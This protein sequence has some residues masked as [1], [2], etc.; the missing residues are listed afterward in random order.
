MTP[1]SARRALL[2]SAGRQASGFRLAQIAG[3][4]SE[5]E[6]AYAGLH[7]LC[8]PLLDRLPALPQPQADALSVA[9]GITSG[10]PPGRFLVG[11]AALSL[12]WWLRSP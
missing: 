10:A 4:E 7:Q 9:F 8:A 6:L 5:L 3:V 12:A 11:L 2:D 1:G